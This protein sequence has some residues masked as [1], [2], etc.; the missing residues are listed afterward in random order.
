MKNESKTSS[1]ESKIKKLK[2]DEKTKQK[3][4]NELT[5]SALNYSI[6]NV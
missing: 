2:C 3:K 4:L 5:K 1:G 6:T